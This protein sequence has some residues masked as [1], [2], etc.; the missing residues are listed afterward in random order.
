MIYTYE[1]YLEK[2]KILT[3]EQCL[4]IHRLMIEEIADDKDAIEL[5]DEL[6]EKAAEY[7]LLRAQWTFKDYSWK[8]NEDPGR[9][10]K[11]NSLIIKF[12]Q[13]AKYLQIQ[14]KK[15]I[16]REMLGDVQQDKYYRKTIGDMACFLT[17]IH[18]IN[19]R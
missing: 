5:Y 17:Y 2:P 11:H 13:L 18:G 15:C 6:L 14:G 12:N 4:E 3:I 10:A 7:T 1:E 8:M 19:G 9:T 16:W